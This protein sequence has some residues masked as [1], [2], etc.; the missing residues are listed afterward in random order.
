MLSSICTVCESPAHSSGQEKHWTTTC[1]RQKNV[2]KISRG[3][4]CFFGGGGGG[5]H[6]NCFGADLRPDMCTLIVKIRSNE[7]TKNSRQR[8]R[9]CRPDQIVRQRKVR[10]GT[11]LQ[12]HRTPFLWLES[13]PAFGSGYFPVWQVWLPI[14]SSSPWTPAEA[15]GKNRVFHASDRT[16]DNNQI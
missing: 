10:R 15:R 13:T 12:A 4:T 14:S 7:E 8:R 11:S 1:K 16:K 3:L 2:H 6:V 5:I 9:T